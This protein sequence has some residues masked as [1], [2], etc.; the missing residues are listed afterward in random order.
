MAFLATIALN[1]LSGVCTTTSFCFKSY[2]HVIYE[3]KKTI[4]NAV[5]LL[6]SRHWTK[7][8]PDFAPKLHPCFLRWLPT[9]YV[10]EFN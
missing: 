6:F 3:K 9:K 1:F 2:P 5:S 8:G 4:D 10:R 7:L